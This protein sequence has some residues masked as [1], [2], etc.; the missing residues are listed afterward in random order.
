MKELKQCSGG[1]DSFIASNIGSN[2]LAIDTDD[3]DNC[4]LQSNAFTPFVQR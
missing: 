2:R 3:R 1:I 4:N